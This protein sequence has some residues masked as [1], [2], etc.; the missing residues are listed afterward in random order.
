MPRGNKKNNSANQPI[1]K[2]KSGRVIKTKNKNSNKAANEPLYIESNYLANQPTIITE[3][4]K[5]TT[6]IFD[7][8]SETDQK[9]KSFYQRLVA[10]EQKNKKLLTGICI[11]VIMIILVVFWIVNLSNG[12]INEPP[13]SIDNKYKINFDKTREEINKSMDKVK[14]N[15][16]RMETESAKNGLNKVKET[17]ETNNF[18][19]PDQINRIIE[20]VINKTTNN[21]E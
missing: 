20:P 21:I 14:E 12:L 16:K 19:T 13:L 10:M 1:N 9:R 15:L 6:I 11:A 7:E 3:E 18:L 4:T 8:V 17:P 5:K 2:T